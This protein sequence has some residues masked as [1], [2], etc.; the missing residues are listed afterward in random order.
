MSVLVAVRRWLSS[1]RRYVKW[2]IFFGK[3]CL[4]NLVVD[5]VQAEVEGPLGAPPRH[6][7]ER[8]EGRGRLAE[9]A[10]TRPQPRPLVLGVQLSLGYL[11]Q[12]G[13]LFWV[14]MKVE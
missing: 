9:R 6:G 12:F 2:E 13:A 4:C 5:S 3:Q 10:R 11:A 8:R 1:K 14:K 7:G